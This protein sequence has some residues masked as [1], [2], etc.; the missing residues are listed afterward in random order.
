MFTNETQVLQR[1][2]VLV[3]CH[4]LAS[5]QR[6]S[7]YFLV[8]QP[9]SWITA[10][11]FCQRHYVDLAVLST[12][13][14]YF[15]L[16]NAT[17]ANKVSFW[18]GLQRQSVFSD[19]KWVNGEELRYQHWFRRNYEGRCASLEAMLKKDKKLLARYCKEPHMVVCQGP[20]SP[21]SVTVDSVG[22]CHVNLSWNVSAFM[23]M[24]P[25][26]YNVTIC[27]STC[28][29]LLQNNTNGSAF[30]NV[31]ISNLTSAT[32][33][34]I[35]VSAFIVRSDSSTGGI[36]ILQNKPTTV[37]V[38][39][40]DSCEQHKIILIVF[41]LLMSVAASLWIF[42]CVMKTDYEESPVELS[43]V[44]VVRSVQKTRG[45]S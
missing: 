30:M 5:G 29:T 12:Q 14:Q 39:T 43:G 28:H 26:S 18:L 15:T 37:Q 40:A 32:D 8:Q 33:H 11:K 2:V 25:H 34:F 45:V 6:P 7:H 19:W 23:Q 27:S 21:Q 44:E 38:K 35:E 3:L 17:A 20:V 41:V 10:R 24:T 36:V 42:Y 22:S 31:N 13:E 4:G 16:L 1:L 9:M